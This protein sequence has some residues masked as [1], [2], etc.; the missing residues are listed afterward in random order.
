MHGI[1]FRLWKHH[2]NIFLMVVAKGDGRWK[3]FQDGG[4]F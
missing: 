2:Q 1:R 3:G 4:Y